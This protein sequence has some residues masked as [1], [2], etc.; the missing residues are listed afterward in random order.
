M[1]VLNRLEIEECVSEIKDR[2]MKTELISK[3]TI[4]KQSCDL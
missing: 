2:S 1:N 4:T 3:T